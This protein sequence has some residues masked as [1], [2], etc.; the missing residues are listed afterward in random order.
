VRVRRSPPY[1]TIILFQELAVRLLASVCPLLRDPE[2]T[3]RDQAFATM[4]SFIERLR[5][6][7]E[8]PELLQEFGE[9]ANCY[10]TT[11]ITT[12]TL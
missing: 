2:K 6:V 11:S 12:S 4:E 5:K 7:S 1:L 10:S 3:V 8:D 9:S